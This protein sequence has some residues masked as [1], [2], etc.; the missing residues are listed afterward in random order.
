[1]VCVAVLLALMF[2]EPSYGWDIR[3]WLTPRAP[4]S[5]A[6]P[7]DPTLA[8]QNESLEAELAQLQGVA[9]EIPQAP[10]GYIR[11]MVYSRYPLNFKNELLVNAGSNEGVVQGKAVVFQGVLIGSVEKVFPDSSLVLTV[12]D[13]SF[14][15]PVR[16]GS[17]GYDALLE[18]GADPKATSIQKNT[19]IAV[20]DIVYSAA[21]TFP[22]GLPVA[23]IAATG[24]TSDNL[25]ENATLSFA[26]DMNDIQTV[27]IAP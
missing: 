23:I 25:F 9:A 14:K 12:F 15:A 7:D 17:G 24:T 8:A 1:M 2:L 20:G 4:A 11:A 16:V 3:S 13:A 10:S 18:G 21:P 22:Y 5:L 27:L 19:N 6:L 26:Y